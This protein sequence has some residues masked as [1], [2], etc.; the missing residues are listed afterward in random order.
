M[1]PLPLRPLIG[2]LGAPRRLEDAPELPSASS[3]KEPRP[4]SS[5]NA[6]P[7]RGDADLRVVSQTLRPSP[8]LIARIWSLAPE[9]LA[10]GSDSP[11]TP[12]TRVAGDAKTVLDARDGVCLIDAGPG[13]WLFPLLV[14][15]ADGAVYESPTVPETA[16]A[17]TVRGSATPT[18]TT[19]TGRTNDRYRFPFAVPGDVQATLWLVLPVGATPQIAGATPVGKTAWNGPSPDTLALFPEVKSAANSDTTSP[20]VA[21]TNGRDETAPLAWMV[22]RFEQPPPAIWNVV[23]TTDGHVPTAI[24][25]VPPSGMEP[26]QES[27]NDGAA[28]EATR[29]TATDSLAAANGSQS[30]GPNTNRLAGTVTG[31]WFNRHTIQPG[32]VETETE[33]RLAGLAPGEQSLTLR[34]AQRPRL[35]LARQG[36]QPLGVT[37]REMPRCPRRPKRPRRTGGRS[38]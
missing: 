38:R 17:R 31:T 34:L 28:A 7:E 27:G 12:E 10:G 36:N 6:A 14:H 20:S 33:V 16:A 8:T 13:R 30:V 29:P 23:L 25:D 37:D 32:W 24:T 9:S 22:W 35:L 3:S 18:A 21:A 15:P 11:A 4:E 1:R 5:E 19:P 2:W 26:G